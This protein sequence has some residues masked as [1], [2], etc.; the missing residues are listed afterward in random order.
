MITGQVKVGDKVWEVPEWNAAPRLV[1]IT[2][3]NE[4]GA[5]ANKHH[6]WPVDWH[7]VFSTEQE[8][9]DGLLQ[10]AEESVDHAK[11]ALKAAKRSLER[12]KKKYVK[13]SA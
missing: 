8:A 13:A 6:V 12:L 3:V 5:F 4:R 9:I 7:R 10:R 2:L 11:V 1:T